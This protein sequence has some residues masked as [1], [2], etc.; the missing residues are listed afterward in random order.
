MRVLLW[1]PASTGCGGGI[2]VRQLSFAEQSGTVDSAGAATSIAFVVGIVAFV[3]VLAA[4]WPAVLWLAKRGPVK[5]THAMLF[6][7]AMANVPVAIGGSARAVCSPRSS[8]WCRPAVLGHF[9]PR[10]GSARATC[11]G[12]CGT[13]EIEFE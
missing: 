9:H 12:H 7:V 6:G 3:F 4:A 2:G 10:H 1:P 5:L 11:R 13:G 8:V